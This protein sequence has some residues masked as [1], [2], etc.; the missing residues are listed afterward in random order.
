MR[1]LLQHPTKLFTARV[2][3]ATPTFYNESRVVRH[4]SGYRGRQKKVIMMEVSHI[5]SEF[6]D[7]QP[8]DEDKQVSMQ[9]NLQPTN[10]R[11]AIDNPIVLWKRKVNFDLTE[12][13]G[14]MEDVDRDDLTADGKGEI[15]PMGKLFFGVDSDLGAQL[16]TVLAVGYGWLV[17]MTPMEAFVYSRERIS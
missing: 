10:S 8:I 16:A 3:Q 12:G 9:I 11:K 6:Q 2:A 5:V 7:S 17:E 4:Y 15:W 1:R 13:G 14:M